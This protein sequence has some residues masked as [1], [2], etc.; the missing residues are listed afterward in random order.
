M[1]SPGF[2]P[3]MAFRVELTPR[4]RQDLDRIYDGV[5]REAP[6][7]GVPWV[8]RFERSILALSNFP[9]RC[10]VEPKLSSRR[11]TVRK[12]VFGTTRYKYRVYFAI[13]G[14]LV[15]V[16]HIRHGSRKEPGRV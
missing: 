1:Y 14:D 12:L 7:A 11:Q 16:V 2:A 15:S 13:I 6:V 3:A 9:E 8:E 4:A 5:I 10:T